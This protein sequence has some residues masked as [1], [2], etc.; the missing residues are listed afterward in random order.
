[1]DNKMDNKIIIH[2][3]STGHVSASIC[4]Y[5][6]GQP[7]NLF[8]SYVPGVDLGEDK[9][10]NFK[11]I[12][13]C[14][15]TNK[16]DDWSQYIT[17]EQA[18]ILKFIYNVIF[19]INKNLKDFDEFDDSEEDFD[20]Y[21]DYINMLN[22]EIDKLKDELPEIYKDIINTKIKEILK[23][24][25][26]NIEEIGLIEKKFN[27][28]F[29]INYF[30]SQSKVKLN[31]LWTSILNLLS[32]MK[33]KGV[34]RNSDDRVLIKKPISEE[35]IPIADINNGFLF[36]LNHKS[37][38][39]VINNYTFDE[40][41]YK[42]LS[43]HHN[44]VGYVN[45]ILD[46]LGAG[47]FVDLKEISKYHRITTGYSI[48]ENIIKYS[49]SVNNIIMQLNQRAFAILS[50]QNITQ[51]MLLNFI[52]D[53]NYRYIS[54][55][56]ALKNKP[57]LYQNIDFDL[58]REIDKYN[59]FPSH[60]FMR[61]SMKILIKLINMSENKYNSNIFIYYLFAEIH[62]TQNFISYSEKD[63][64]SYNY[65]ET[66]SF[67]INTIKF[68]YINKSFGLFSNKA[69]LPLAKYVCQRLLQKDINSEEDVLG[70]LS[71][72]ILKSRGIKFKKHDY[73]FKLNSTNKLYVETLI[74]NND[75]IHKFTAGRIFYK[76]LDNNLYKK[77]NKSTRFISILVKLHEEILNKR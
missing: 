20:D 12:T 37:F 54:Y 51:T 47:A 53:N 29:Q 58:K 34:V 26:K 25:P 5:F 33:D 44:C 64:I 32:Y 72:I 36:G 63:Y 15:M 59:L 14:I 39:Y 28:E 21:Q 9:K 49:R 23:N 35:T 2:Y 76:D 73:K 62:R 75:R 68:S 61:D 46:R 31:N 1:M 50:R 27:E 74:S 10:S 66:V 24:I 41:Y 77:T 55:L 19:S 8:L 67:I 11:K 70:I 4:F 3:H 22:L 13:A 16:S 7:D 43:M 48:P 57:D 69:S 52:K 18:S 17:E 42:L 38:L 45:K 65:N 60:I 56:Y 30:T 71:V 6:N 40:T